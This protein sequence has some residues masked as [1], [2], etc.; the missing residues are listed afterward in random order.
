MAVVTNPILLI[1]AVAGLLALTQ[2]VGDAGFSAEN[3]FG[4]DSRTQISSTIE[5]SKAENSVPVMFRMEAPK[6]VETR[7]A[8]PLSCL[9]IQAIDEIEL[10]SEPTPDADC[11]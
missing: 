3:H 5:P 8:T 10:I 9:Q 7:E 11:E 6:D 1:P 4:A 2:T